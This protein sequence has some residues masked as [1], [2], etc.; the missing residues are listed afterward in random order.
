MATCTAHFKG[1]VLS[2]LLQT[3][4]FIVPILCVI[5]DPS[6]GELIPLDRKDE[7]VAS[8][9]NLVSLLPAPS[10]VGPDDIIRNFLG[11]VLGVQK[12]HSINLVRRFAQSK[13]EFRDISGLQLERSLPMN[14]HRVLGGCK[15]LLGLAMKGIFP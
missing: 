10:S 9:L 8:N 2:R 6:R 5:G 3:S 1:F 11:R 15:R 12:N 14:H 7:V 13:S 4:V